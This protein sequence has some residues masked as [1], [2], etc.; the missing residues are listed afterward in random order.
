MFKF[1]E[2]LDCIYRNIYYAKMHYNLLK[3]MFDDYKDK[4]EYKDISICIIDSLED[5]CFIKLGKIYKEDNQSITIQKL[6]KKIQSDKNI[7]NN[8]KS[9]IEY[10]KNKIEEINNSELV[11]KIIN[12][13]DR[14]YTH[15]DKRNSNGILSFSKD[16]VLNMEELKQLVQFTFDIVEY[17][18]INIIKNNKT[19]NYLKYWEKVDKQYENIKTKISK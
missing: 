2:N 14:Y 1:E 19:S 7:N 16:E 4:G 8:D 3:K 6:L 15:I 12:M 5:S 13:R 17:I 11:F 18:Y 10:A 9:I